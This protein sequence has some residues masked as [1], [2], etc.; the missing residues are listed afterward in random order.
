[1]ASLIR[2]EV[3]HLHA[4]RA[5]AE[6]VHARTQRSEGTR[7]G[8]TTKPRRRDA[9]SSDTVRRVAEA[10]RNPAGRVPQVTEV[11]PIE[12]PEARTTPSDDEIRERAYQIYLERGGAPGDPVADWTQAER[13][14]RAAYARRSVP[15]SD[16][17]SD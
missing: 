11:K 2:R 1:M 13:E 7:G 15:E 12:A 16:A 17:P 6:D 8:A 5:H 3:P 14:L 10:L 9:L 4:V